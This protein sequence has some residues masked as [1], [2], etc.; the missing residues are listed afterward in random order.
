[1]SEDAYARK[2]GFPTKIVMVVLAGIVIVLWF[3]FG[4][5]YFISPM[6]V[7]GSE[8]PTIWLVYQGDIYT[9]LRGSYC[10]TN[11]CVDT[12]FQ[13]PPGMIDIVNGTSV[14][15]MINSLVRPS[16]VNAL[17]FVIDENDNPLQVG[18]LVNQG[19]DKYGVN[20]QHG[21]YIV[22]VLANWKDIGDVSYA[23]KISVS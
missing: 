5:G 19:N 20:L 4:Y 8:P 18:E 23:F 17:V 22:N 13:N 9:G 3:V 1:M 6:P 10:W 7:Q 21:T 14:S 11:M 15:F 12:I 2:E 16:I